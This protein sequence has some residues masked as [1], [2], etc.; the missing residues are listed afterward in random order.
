ME[1]DEGCSFKVLLQPFL[2]PGTHGTLPGLSRG[3]GEII[4][5]HSRG[6]RADRPVRRSR[7]AISAFQLG[8]A[9]AERSAGAR[10]VGGGHAHTTGEGGSQTSQLGGSLYRPTGSPWAKA[11]PL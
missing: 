4:S 10:S 5:V 2:S 3:M 6:G 11:T 1:V 7:A 8:A 9:W